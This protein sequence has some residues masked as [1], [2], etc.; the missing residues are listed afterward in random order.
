MTTKHTPGPWTRKR[1]I[2][3]DDTISRLVFA[4]DDLIATVH[5]LEDAGHEAFANAR[6]IAAAPELLAALQELVAEWD[7]RH[8]DEDHRTGYTLDTWG[9]QLARAAIATATGEGQA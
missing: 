7:A 4:G 2:P 1:A 9:V 3:D 5:D 8:A 6:L